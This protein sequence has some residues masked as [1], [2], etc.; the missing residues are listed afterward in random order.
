MGGGGATL[1]GLVDEIGSEAVFEDDDEDLEDA[2]GTDCCEADFEDDEDPGDTGGTGS[3]DAGF[4]DG[5]T[6][7]AGFEDEASVEGL[8]EDDGGLVDEEDGLNVG[9]GTRDVEEVDDSLREEEDDDCFDEDG[10][11]EV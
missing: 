10:S 5:N 1:A 9:D 8:K 2:G 11:M 6:P 4:D 3:C 7:E